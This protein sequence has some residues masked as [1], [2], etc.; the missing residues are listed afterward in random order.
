M[1]F[2]L[3]K[4]LYRRFYSFYY[5]GND[6]SC[7]LCSWQGITFP[8][9]RCPQCESLP[10]QRLIPYS[11]T[12]S[13]KRFY[14]VLHIGP[15]YCEYIYVKERLKPVQYDRVDYEKNTYSNITSDITKD[16]LK[17]DYY[18]LV[19]IWHVLEHVPED[20]KAMYNLFNSLKIKGTLIFSVPIY[21]SGNKKTIEIDNVSND[22]YNALYGHPDHVRSC[23]YD[24]IDRFKYLGFDS[25]HEI[26]VKE[27]VDI[28]I[29][30][31]GLSRGHIAWLCIK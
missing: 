21:P 1:F 2:R 29:K 6:V 17:K 18:D 25:I 20:K 11:V 27:L 26:N 12:Q 10:R 9:G 5:R 8:N 31:F 4:Y 30:K 19:I 23:G 7:L 24:Y 15:N 22:N 16:E 13:N 3:K 14:N 28:D